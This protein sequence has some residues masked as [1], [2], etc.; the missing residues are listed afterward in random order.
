MVRR[1]GLTIVW[2]GFILYAVLAAPPDHP[3]T[4]DLILR[5]S[6]GDWGEINPTIVALFNLM[7]IWPLIYASLGLVD[8][9]KQWLPAWPFLLGSF[10]LGAFALLP[11]LIGRQPHPDSPEA[12]DSVL[13]QLVESR[14]WAGAI[15]LVATGLILYGLG[16]GEWVAF[17][18]QW[19]GQ[20]FIHIM[21]LDFCLLWLLVPTLLGDDMARR[22]LKGRWPWALMVV[23]LL[24]VIAY[25]ILRPPLPKAGSTAA[26]TS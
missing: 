1:I 19:R 15:G 11:Y 26:Q 17:V 22:G 14:W 3:A 24:G 16:A 12:V 8:G 25:L 6:R 21:G 18:E 7:G 23:P 5:L 2:L 13:L 9:Q 20:R 10:G 4:M